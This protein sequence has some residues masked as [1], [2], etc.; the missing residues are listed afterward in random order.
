MNVEEA[1]QLLAL[2]KANYN[3]AFKNMG[4]QEKVMLVK[5]WAFVLQDIPADIVALAFM[6]LVSTHKWLPTPAEIRDQVRELYYSAAYQDV[7]GGSVIVDEQA[8]RARRYIVDQTSHLRGDHATQLSLDTILHRGY[9]KSLG[10]GKMEFWGTA[11][12]GRVPL[13]ESGT[14]E[15]NE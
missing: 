3:Y 15:E 11:G 7:C 14:E 5:S 6:Q 12:A 13:P 8:E 10:T 9:G 1:N 4:K 2:V